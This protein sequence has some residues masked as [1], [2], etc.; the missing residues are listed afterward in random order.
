MVPQH[1]VPLE[2]K[3]D[4]RDETDYN[5]FHPDGRAAPG[6]EMQTICARLMQMHYC[7][8]ETSLRNSLVG[9]CCHATLHAGG[10]KMTRGFK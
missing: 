1:S 7:E 5:F 9:W 8:V 4:V 3:I 10:R 6:R 2:A